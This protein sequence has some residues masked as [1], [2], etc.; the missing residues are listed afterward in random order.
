MVLR[1]RYQPP[2]LSV[3]SDDEPEL[4][5]LPE[6]PGPAIVTLSEWFHNPAWDP[7]GLDAHNVAVKEFLH[8]TTVAKYGQ[9]PDK[10]AVAAALTEDDVDLICQMFWLPHSHGAL[11]RDLQYCKENV[12]VMYMEGKRTKGS[13]RK[14]FIYLKKKDLLIFMFTG[15]LSE[16]AEDW[17]D[18]YGGVRDIIETF[19][20]VCDKATHIANRDLLYDLSPYITNINM[21]L[22]GWNSYLKWVA[23]HNCKN[24]LQGGP[25]LCGLPGG[26]AG[27]L[28]RLYPIQ[29]VLYLIETSSSVSNRN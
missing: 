29:V 16:A 4:R 21:L 28:M 13:D 1:S 22:H 25:T 24:P 11:V 27:D 6:R 19:G 2:L 15:D 5:V 9:E 20:N 18:C 17:L 3:R 14:L 8:T 26:L 10:D 7:S 23:V 12:A